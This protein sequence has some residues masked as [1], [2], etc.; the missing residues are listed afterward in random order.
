MARRVTPLHIR[1]WS[2]VQVSDTSVCWP[3]QGSVNAAGYGRLGVDG[4]KTVL[5]HRA[6]WEDF[7]Q[8]KIP[9]GN[10]LRHSCDNPVC[11]NPWHLIPGTQGENIMDAVSR[12]RVRRGER[13]AGSR[14]D[15]DKV[16]EIRKRS[17]QSESALGLA[18]EYG[19]SVSQI[20]R[21]VR[22]QAWAHV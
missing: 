14:L 3:W 13:H 12:G 19:V 4:T 1:L 21:V 17:G 9:D 8:E 22:R 20:H 15:A 2:R 18:A 11:C 5:A 7:F 10:V 6:A 16:R